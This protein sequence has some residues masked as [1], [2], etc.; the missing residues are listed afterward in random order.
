MP[1]T[2]VHIDG[3]LVI[4]MDLKAGSY[5]ICNGMSFAAGEDRRMMSTPDGLVDEEKPSS[6]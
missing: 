2:T 3:K 1:F 5:V 4:D 6:R